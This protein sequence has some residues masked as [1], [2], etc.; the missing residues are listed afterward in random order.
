VG[1]GG[2]A[3]ALARFAVD[4]RVGGRAATFLVNVLGS[5]ALGVLATGPVGTTT[6]LVAGVGFCGAFTTFSSFAVSIDRLVA[7]GRRRE[8]AVYAVA[9]LVVALAAVA[10]GS[11]VGRAL[12]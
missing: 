4:T 7:E 5:L 10:V 8:A 2:V 6:Q 3:G 9:T 12:A 1:A 11:V